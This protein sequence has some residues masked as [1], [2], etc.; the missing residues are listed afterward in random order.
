[1]PVRLK[2]P[3]GNSE[4]FEDR[5]Q[6]YAKKAA[7][8]AAMQFESDR[9]ESASIRRLWITL[10]IV[11]AIGILVVVFLKPCPRQTIDALRQPTR[12]RTGDEFNK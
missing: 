11:A 2:Y 12:Y 9:E 7:I 8:E 10:G 1:M 3:D 6:A 5:Q 4:V